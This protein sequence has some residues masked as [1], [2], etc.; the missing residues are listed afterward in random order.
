MGL[1]CAVKA[2]DVY[3]YIHMGLLVRVL[4]TVRLTQIQGRAW[5][6]GVCSQMSHKLTEQGETSKHDVSCLE[7][8]LYDRYYCLDRA[9]RPKHSPQKETFGRRG[10]FEHSTEEY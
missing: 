5:S 3:N 8:N 2:A 6:N 4:G 10:R 1:A 7:T 9:N